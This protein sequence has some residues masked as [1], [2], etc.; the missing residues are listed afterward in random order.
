[1]ENSAVQEKARKNDECVLEKRRQVGGSA[2]CNL[3]TLVIV[4]LTEILFIIRKELEIPAAYESCQNGEN[5][6]YCKKV[7]EK[8]CL[9]RKDGRTGQEE[10]RGKHG[11]ESC[12]ALR[13]EV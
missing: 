5:E 6:L 10:R 11:K 13:V 4:I 9:S 2:N 1:M 3:E 12:V 8:I 7:F